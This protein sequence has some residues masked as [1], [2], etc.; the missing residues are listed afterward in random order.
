M[1]ELTLDVGLFGRDRELELLHEGVV[2]HDRPILISGV[3]GAGKSR[4]LKEL[5]AELQSIHTVLEGTFDPYRRNTPYSAVLA[6]V[7][8]ALHQLLLE[9]AAQIE[10]WRE[11]VRQSLGAKLGSALE[12]LPTLGVVLDEPHRPN[13]AQSVQPQRRSAAALTEVVLS[14][15][16]DERPVLLL[17]DDLQWLDHASADLIRGL[18]TS[19]RT[20][21]RR[22]VQL[23]FASRPTGLARGHAF[24]ELL[25]AFR[26]VRHIDLQGLHLRDVESWLS[27][28]FGFAGPA[29]RNLATLVHRR[30]NGNPLF[31]EQ[32]LY[33]LHA[34]GQLRYHRKRER[35]TWS[36][37][38]VDHEDI[39][40]SVVQL[41]VNR[42]D[43]LCK[44]CRD[45][46][47]VAASLGR[48]FPADQLASALGLSREMVMRDLQPAIE[49]RI[50]RADNEDSADLD[51]PELEADQPEL[52]FV[53]DRIRESINRRTPRARQREVH[54]LLGRSLA[55]TANRNNDELFEVVRHLNQVSEELS[56][57][58][59][60]ELV[61]LN[62]SAGRRAHWSPR[63][64]LG[65]Y[66]SAIDLLD[67]CAQDP[68]QSH[69]SLC[70]EAHQ[71]GARV[72]ALAG[73]DERME[74]LAERVCER[75]RAPHD[76]VPVYEVK[77]QSYVLHNQLQRAV[78][79]G[80]SIL[81]ALGFRIPREPS[82]L[83]LRRRL[84]SVRLRL[85]GRSVDS[86]ADRPRMTNESAL[87]QCRILRAMGSAIYL[88]R[89]RL[90]PLVVL[91]MLDLVLEHG[92]PP[93]A[94]FVYSS[95]GLLLSGLGKLERA[96]QFG[97]LAL[98]MLERTEAKEQTSRTIVSTAI[99]RH[100]R[101]SLQ[102]VL[103]ALKSGLEA[104][105]DDGDLDSAGLC[106]AVYSTL[107]FLS[108]RNLEE[109]DEELGRISHE[110]AAIGHHTA[111][112]HALS[113]WQ[114]VRKLRGPLDE[115]HDSTGPFYDERQR[116]E[117][118]RA[119]N[120]HS[121]LQN[122]L[123]YQRFLNYL[124][125]SAGEGPLEAR[126]PTAHLGGLNATA[127]AAF[128]N[129]YDAL[130]ELSR[131]TRV[132][133][134][135]QRAILRR[136][137]R[138]LR[139]LRRLARHSPHNHSHHVA[140]TRGELCRVT[141]RTDEALGHFVHA[142]ELAEDNG[143]V[144]DSA[145]AEELTAR[146]H[147]AQGRSA[148]AATA[149]QRALAHYRRWGANAK[150]EALER[151]FAD[152]LISRPEPSHPERRLERGLIGS[153]LSLSRSIELDELLP[154][155]LQ[156]A[157]QV[158][159]ADRVALVTGQSGE[160]TIAAGWQST[161]EPTSSTHRRGET[162]E[163]LLLPA[164]EAAFDGNE[165]IVINDVTHHDDYGNQPYVLAHQPRS[166]L[167][168]PL[169]RSGDV[170]GVLYLENHE[171]GGAFTAERVELLNLLAA[172][173]TIS[174]E[175]ARL[176]ESLKLEA[177]GRRTAERQLLQAQKMEAIGRLAGG[178]AHDFNNLL[179]VIRG[180]CALA[181]S[182]PDP[183]EL[184]D[185]INEI[186]RAGKR[187]Q[188]LTSR[189][190]AFSRQQPSKT[191]HFD[192]N[193]LILDMDKML[194]R[195]VGEEIQLETRLDT[196]AG[197]V[198]GDPSQI[199]Q[200]LLNLIV[201]AR[202]AVADGGRI[203][204]ETS[205]VHFKDSRDLGDR[206]AEAGSYVVISVVDNGCGMSEEIVER[207]FEPFFT[208]KGQGSGTGLGLST[209]FGIVENARGFV[210][211]E[212]R[213]GA[214]SRFEVHLPL[215]VGDAVSIESQ[216]SEPTQAGGDLRL[217]LIEDDTS[218]RRLLVASLRALGYDVVEAIDGDD[219]VAR[220]DELDGRL[221]LVISD[222]AL[223]GRSGLQVV[224]YL[225]QR[226]PTLPFLLISGYAER[227][228]QLAELLPSE[229]HFLAKP[230]RP[231]TLAQ[232]VRELTAPPN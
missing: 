66:L 40:E 47:E 80:R 137:R 57:D 67:S 167:C 64:S 207:V 25:D 142:L 78:D 116:L 145:L 4:L 175:N 22:R 152:V 155:L 159:S 117:Q 27:A 119:R 170:S 107:S 112:E 56:S 162:G 16:T 189:L 200:V 177:A 42:I 18:A 195:L 1:S 96:H 19:S 224:E 182:E 157:A 87:A 220:L 203:A 106:L 76:K 205:S 122:Q 77:I 169:A 210:Q 178:V 130:A 172:Q 148:L 197:T 68:W 59:R 38:Q 147:L 41:M 24:R 95:Y 75:A 138:W 164:V 93:T 103:P 135:E 62:L 196:S 37:R 43:E 114:T 136:A 132:H 85:F 48:R 183:N 166:I 70:L 86:L 30:A 179:T 88:V 15:S 129:Y 61:R 14:F 71:E 5:R 209:V 229:N 51:R 21:A 185:M 192:V 226:W 101:E 124:V 222:V 201:N 173:A 105:R 140:M 109:L 8:S 211:V 29:V 180:Y 60:E 108:G 225:R 150:V 69:Y 206:T 216:D 92:N 49:A 90:M 186:D 144:Q 91:E 134:G 35:W 184:E 227:Q 97:Q 36:M 158:S 228:D 73:L 149:L 3:S 53:H 84:L 190:L 219:G 212:S 143:Y 28:V 44:P 188:S 98:R 17:L 46:L 161:S 55:A 215:A 194:R 221:H 89:P 121:A 102:S 26:T 11:R 79:C 214:G 39:G 45:L 104:G 20:S 176:Y 118:H 31:V 123:F 13:I 154:E 82:A 6:A 187:A 181:I 232:R 115:L 10:P 120:N 126:R 168:L 113:C 213:V 72:A 141:G 218:V 131:Y 110:L 81:Y 204:I 111:R 223:P 165:P 133:K 191:V 9:P 202:D 94:P 125:G 217:L 153:L 7:D 230:F 2:E 128:S 50:L 127:I 32:Y 139:I 63:G 193:E 174:L 52:E 208:T 199:E 171:S 74:K 156:R 34:R 33:W 12:L 58:E 163:Q 99:T 231:Q 65:H 151:R 198:A 23:V 146:C 100:W 83:R 160:L 54:R